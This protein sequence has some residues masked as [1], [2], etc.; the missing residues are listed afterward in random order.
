MDQSLSFSPGQGRA[1]PM[2]STNDLC[3]L[4]ALSFGRLN[5][6]TLGPHETTTIAPQDITCRAASTTK[7][8]AWDAK[9]CRRSALKLPASRFTRLRSY[10]LDYSNNTG[11]TCRPK[12]YPE[13]V[14]DALSGVKMS[15]ITA[16][17]DDTPPAGLLLF[18]EIMGERALPLRHDLLE[19]MP[20]QG[21]ATPSIRTRDFPLQY[22]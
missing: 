9:F 12:L 22:L 19:P 2:A 10:F 1:E 21:I 20:L 17:L 8:V 13:T 7:A 6:G 14:G 18:T 3:N 15:T 5:T 11:T 16:N 4:L